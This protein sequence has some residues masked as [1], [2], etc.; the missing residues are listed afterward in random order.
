MM[1]P[2]FTYFSIDVGDV[3]EFECGLFLYSE[4]NYELMESSIERIR[5]KIVD[6][7][8]PSVTYDHSQYSED[9][10]R[11][12][13]GR[14]ER[15][16]NTTDLRAVVSL[17]YF[18]AR[19]DLYQYGQN[20]V[21]EKE[22]PDFDYWF[23]FKLRQYDLGLKH[24]K[25]FLNF[26]LENNFKNNI[27]EFN[28]FLELIL[29]QYEGLH[30]SKRVNQQV[31][32]FMATT[33]APKQDKNQSKTT[34]NTRKRP[35]SNENFHSFKLVELRSNPRY[36]INQK[37]EVKEVFQDLID[38]GFIREKSSFAT[39]EKVFSNQRI[40]EEKRLQW[41]GGYIY[42]KLFIRFLLDNQKIESMGNDHWVVTTQCFVDHDG[43]ELDIIK[44][45]KANG[46]TKNKVEK[47]EGILNRL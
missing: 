12:Y 45:S 16:L 14:V 34:V 26:H 5:N 44:V 30:I 40:L 21:I 24:L 36:F 20:I 39:F 3:W 4:D 35:R 1:Q 11:Y 41:I 22:E 17:G 28:E 29:L 2:C 42:L 47:L 31:K 15:F 46:G 33:I 32:K 6:R 27:S 13:S 7:G 23:A 9:M 19:D 37:S 10:I 43:A 25:G 8:R 18:V 38:Y